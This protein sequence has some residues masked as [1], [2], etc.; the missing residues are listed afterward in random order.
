MVVAFVENIV[1]VPVTDVQ[2]L[3][4]NAKDGQ[5]SEVGIHHVDYGQGSFPIRVLK[6]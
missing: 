2:V 3:R 4:S 5:T 6:C 1:S